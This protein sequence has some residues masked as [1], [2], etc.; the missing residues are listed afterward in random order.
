MNGCQDSRDHRFYQ[1]PASRDNGL[2]HCHR[3]LDD[4]LDNGKGGRYQCLKDSKHCRKDKL[5]TI[6]CSCNDGLNDR[7]Y[8][9]DHRLDSYK[10]RQDYELNRAK[11]RKKMFWMAVHAV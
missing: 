9:L 4:R 3:R 6:P 7:K 11:N 8:G 5:D 1:I 10:S 2:D